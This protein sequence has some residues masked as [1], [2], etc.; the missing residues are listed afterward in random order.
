MSRKRNR[1]SHKYAVCHFLLLSHIMPGA[2]L[3]STGCIQFCFLQKLCHVLIMRCWQ[4]VMWLVL[5]SILFFISSP[6]VF[7]LYIALLNYRETINSGLVLPHLYVCNGDITFKHRIKSPLYHVFQA[8]NRYGPLNVHF[9]YFFFNKKKR[10]FF[11]LYFVTVLL[12]GLPTEIR[13][14]Y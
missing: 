3:C 4:S 12:K 11:S 2:L 9:F 5:M 14:K 6:V 13:F 7:T 10:I 1:F 8:N